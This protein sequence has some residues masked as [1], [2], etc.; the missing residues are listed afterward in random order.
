[1]TR[2]KIDVGFG[3]T[4][5]T[6][7]VDLPESEPRPW[8]ARAELAVVGRELPRIDG[9]LKVSG[10]ARYT[11]DISLPRMLHAAVLRASLPAATIKS[12]SLAK[13]EKRPGVVGVLALVKPG[14][15][16]LFAGQDVAA[17]AASRP[18]L[19]RDAL[20]YVE[21]EYEAAPFVVDVVTAAKAT[22][23]RVHQGNVAERQTEGD[24]PG[25]GRGG[26]AEG[27]VRP[28]PVSQRG[29]V[30]A[31]LKKAAVVHEAE[32]ITQVQTH[33]ALETHGIIV[34]WR[35]DD[36]MDVW[37][38][39]QGTF[40]VRDE[41]AQIFGL[42]PR[43]VEVVS[44]YV[45]GGF[46]AKFGASA[47]GTRLGFVAG[48]LARTT[49]RPVKLMCDRHEEQVCTGNRPD[50]FQR[51]RVGV[52]ATGR[53]VGIHAKSLGTAGI[54][55]GAGIGRNAFGVYTRCPNVRVE[56]SD[57]FTN[58]GPATA[59][60]AP[61]HPQGAFALELALDELAA[62]AKLDPLR[63]RIDHDE[64]PV[65][66]WQAEE[67]AKRFGWTAARKRSA[68]QRARNTR[69]RRGVGMAASIWGDFGRGGA[70][71]VTCR[72]ARDGRVTVENGVQD[73]GTGIG[74][75]MAQVAAEVL[76][77]DPRAIT[78]R[79]GHTAYGPSVGSGGSTTTSSV[80]PAVRNAVEKAK[81]ELIA[82]AA[83][84]LGA[85]PSQV[86]WGAGGTVTTAAGKTLSF[87]ALCKKLPAEEILATGS[88]ARTYGHH[89]ASFMGEPMQQIAGVQFAEVEVD[90][91]TGVVRPVR[92]LAIHDAGRIMNR[93]TARSQ[94][95]GGI[96]LGTSYALLEER[97]MD[98]D[99][100]RMLNPNLE[101]Y[102]I[103]GPRDIPDIEVV[104][105]DV[106]AGNNSTGAIGIGEPATIPTAAAIACAVFDALGVPVRSLPI[107]P[108]KVLAALGKVPGKG[109]PT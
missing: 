20:A 6:I 53:L 30:D 99:F 54:G 108:A 31:A 90:T 3:D 41:L 101:S 71:Q 46:G 67:G 36:A 4:R 58:C 88:R 56:A 80:T 26:T 77:L 35:G 52:D 18:E 70:A 57:V 33:S 73:I 94:V 68:D 107:T 17:V 7:E 49:G 14:D 69:L 92:V 65:R 11:F 21:V 10:R 62:K 15:R 5:T 86:V 102:K 84:Q 28:M 72:I 39:T 13:A 8:D 29:N 74:T 63:L 95:N 40:S 55:T 1:M 24:E 106:Y 75:V 64:H 97:V 45:G 42:D 51:L 82:V 78:V 100:G 60:R 34:A 9:A 93:L 79:I 89:P 66:R 37:C 105:T 96:I 43:N 25:T 50:S 47:P 19:A 83:A 16:V 103:A 81:I 87:A 104:L 85:K 22:A 91:W 27:N 59:M 76:L 23:P 98:R 2:T 61:G 12:I 44:D 32:Y 109:T 38:S 48:E